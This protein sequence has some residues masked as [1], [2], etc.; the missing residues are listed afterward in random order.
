MIKLL[1]QF[2]ANVNATNKKQRDSVEILTAYFESTHAPKPTHSTNQ[3]RQS[4]P[5]QFSDVADLL[6]PFRK[7]QLIPELDDT[8]KNDIRRLIDNL[9]DALPEKSGAAA[10]H[11]FTA[12][13]QPGLGGA[14][15][16]LVEHRGAARDPAAAAGAGAALD[17]TVP[18][19]RA[20]WHR[21]WARRPRRR[22]SSALK[23]VMI[24][25]G[26]MFLAGGCCT[27]MVVKSFT[28]SDTAEV[29]P[30]PSVID[31]PVAEEA[32]PEEAAPEEAAPEGAVPAEDG[33]TEPSSPTRPRSRT[34]AGAPA[35]RPRRS[36]R[37]ASRSR[38]APT[39][40]RA[41]SLNAGR[42]GS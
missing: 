18:R 26:M 27:C 6:T 16:R 22:R 9:C 37:R 7:D 31:E 39:R 42:D 3:L 10:P 28:G 4:V 8:A 13:D 12:A 23:W 2:G 15:E 20:G 35:P 41:R 14:L 19:R 17:A 29:T 30:P 40:S 5:Y 32:V 25:L 11:A 38:R 36:A 33:L 34:S 24:V 1:L 21:S